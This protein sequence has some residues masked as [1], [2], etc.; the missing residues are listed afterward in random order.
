MAEGRPGATLSGLKIQFQ[1]RER[2]AASLAPPPAVLWADLRSGTPSVA[3][4]ACDDVLNRNESD[5]PKMKSKGSVKS[6]FRVTKKGK[7]KCSKPFRG[8]QHAIH[9]GKEKRALRKSLVIDGTWARLIR[10]MLG[11]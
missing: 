11:A 2:P 4:A 10:K 5:M 7:V 3:P 6:R 8:H 9:N 1:G